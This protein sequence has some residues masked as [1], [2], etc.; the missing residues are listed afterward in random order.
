MVRALAEPLRC[1]GLRVWFDERVTGNAEEGLAQS[2]VLV[3]CLSANVAGPEWARL[4]AGTFR[5]R[6]PED[7]ERHVIPLRLDETPIEP[8][9]AQFLSI[10]WKPESRERVF[11][12]CRGMPAGI[13]AGTDER[14]VP[15]Q[16]SVTRPHGP[17]VKRDLE[18]RRPECPLR[19]G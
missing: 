17:R 14:P 8:S 3:L 7:K 10:D 5:F 15:R 1:D 2:R 13:R 9:L 16:N 11:P 6:D 18:S 4:E 19:G 12:V